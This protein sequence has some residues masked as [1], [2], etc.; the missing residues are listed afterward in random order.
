MTPAPTTRETPARVE[1]LATRVAADPTVRL[2]LEGLPV[3]TLVLN[4]CRQILAA[5]PDALRLLGRSGLR[6][7][8]GRRPGEALGCIE[9][10]KG[11]EGCGTGPACAE[12]GVSGALSVVEDRPERTA[13]RPARLL[14]GPDGFRALD[15]EVRASRLRSGEEELLVVCLRDIAAEKRRDVLERV[16]FHDVLNTAGGVQGLSDVLGM[17]GV[18]TADERRELTGEL[19]EA[20]RRLVDEILH[21][22][23]LIAAERGD[24]ECELEELDAADLLDAVR[25]TYARHP[26][27]EGRTIEVAAAPGLRLVSDRALVLRSL[28]NL[29]KNALEAIE[30]GETVRLSAEADA[31]AERVRFTVANPGEI[32]APVRRQIFRRSFSTKSG[33]GRGIGTWSVRLFVERF[34]GGEVKLESDTRDGTRFTISL[35]LRPAD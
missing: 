16:F 14:A 28:G 30:E 33:K 25:R 9:A 13:S 7:V 26:V 24:L 4:R 8:L 15:L 31:T 34:L 23:R 20:V 3:P 11:R 10:P 1:D 35:P 29:L 19:R 22:R 27:A 18:L 17:E 32:P 2:L 12:C 6:G 21:Q 5:S